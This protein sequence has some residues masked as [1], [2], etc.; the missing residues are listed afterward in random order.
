M[1]NKIMNL[2]GLAA[3]LLMVFIM[4]AGLSDNKNSEFSDLEDMPLPEGCTSVLV[5]KLASA[6][7]STMG[8]N[9]SSN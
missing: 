7:G 6:D 9:N 3:V 4:A 5:G 2:L 8:C 1:K